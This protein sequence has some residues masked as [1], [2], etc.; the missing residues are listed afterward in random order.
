LRRDDPSVPDS[1]L[2]GQRCLVARDWFL[3]ELKKHF[4]FAYISKTQPDDRVFPTRWSTRLRYPRCIFA[5]SRHELDSDLF[6][7]EPLSEQEK[8][9]AKDI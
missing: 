2:D 5:A 7:E 3:T 4:E 9:G 8:T 1:S 6:S